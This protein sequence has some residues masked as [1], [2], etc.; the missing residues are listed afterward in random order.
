MTEK[1]QQDV[2]GRL[3]RIE[4]K[5]DG[6]QESLLG[7]GGRIVRLEDEAKWR[8]RA[9]WIHSSVISALMAMLK[10]SAYLGFK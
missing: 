2:I 9:Q 7:P 10:I 1:F 6:F 4:E 5:Q 3:A 8:G